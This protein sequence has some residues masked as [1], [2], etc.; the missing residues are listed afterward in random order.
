MDTSKIS[1]PDYK[2]ICE[3]IGC[4]ADAT[5]EVEIGVGHLG[6]IKLVVCDICKPKFLDYEFV[7]KKKVTP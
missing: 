1:T 4:F 2:P 6:I 3:S 7:L 5:D